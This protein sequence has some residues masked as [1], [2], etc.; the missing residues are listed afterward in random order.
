[1]FPAQLLALYWYNGHNG[2]LHNGSD[3]TYVC[4]LCFDA[5]LTRRYAHSL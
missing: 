4:G 5:F 3:I 2:D 1:M